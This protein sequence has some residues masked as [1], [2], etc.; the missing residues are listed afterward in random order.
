MAN[1]ILRQKSVTNKSSLNRKHFNQKLA[2]F[3]VFHSAHCGICR[4]LRILGTLG[5]YCSG[6]YCILGILGILPWVILHT[7]YTGGILQ[8]CI[9]QWENLIP[10]YLLTLQRH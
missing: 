4:V 10:Q 5:V 8:W 2:L 6:V 9:L 7:G 1:N 3:K